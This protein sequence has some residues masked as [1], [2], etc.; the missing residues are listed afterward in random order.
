MKHKVSYGYLLKNSHVTR[1][2]YWYGKNGWFTDRGRCEALT[3]EEATEALQHGKAVGF[4][5]SIVKVTTLVPDVPAPA[6]KKEKARPRREWKTT[7]ELFTE[8]NF[9]G[10]D[11]LP[12]PVPPA[13]DAA[14][15]WDLRSVSVLERRN[16]WAVI[17]FWQR[18]VPDEKDA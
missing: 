13:R 18:D 7:Y 6:N 1:E 3:L 15:G 2:P 17:F 5:F 12:S 4:D 8:E 10:D 11:G 16:A 9:E 14:G